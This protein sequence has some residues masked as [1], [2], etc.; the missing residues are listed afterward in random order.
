[1]LEIYEDDEDDADVEDVEEDDA[2]V[3]DD[4]C[5]QGGKGQS[6]T[7]LAPTVKRAQSATVLV[8]QHPL[9]LPSPSYPNPQHIPLI[10]SPPPPPSS[11]SLPLTD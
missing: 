2:D 1:M 6:A 11:A 3:E 7:Q 10:S 4:I 8:L 9:P 5:K